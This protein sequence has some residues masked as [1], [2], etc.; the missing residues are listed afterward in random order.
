M[1]A[2]SAP[3]QRRRP[4]SPPGAASLSGTSTPTDSKP[5]GHANGKSSSGNAREEAD[6]DAR[7]R[8]KEDGPVGAASATAFGG[9]RH[10]GAGRAGAIGGLRRREWILVGGICII[11]SFVRLWNLAHPTSVV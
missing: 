1:P 4:A 7:L 6:A 2:L 5:K 11:A 9:P 3:Q 10:R 8:H